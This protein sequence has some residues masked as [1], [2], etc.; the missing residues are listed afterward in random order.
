MTGTKKTKVH[1]S[2]MSDLVCGGGGAKQHF[3][4]GFEPLVTHRG[5]RCTKRIKVN[6]ASRKLT[7]PLLCYP[8]WM[9]G[10]RTRRTRPT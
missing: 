9:A 8:C 3:A 2:V 10:E 4:P 7:R 6:V 1:C 5:P